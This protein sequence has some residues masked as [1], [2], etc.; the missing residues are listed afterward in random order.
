MEKQLQMDLNINHPKGACH[1]TLRDSDDGD[2]GGLFASCSCG[3][4]CSGWPHLVREWI[5]EHARKH[6]VSL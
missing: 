4:S 2:E 5:A 3:A 6:P 1:I